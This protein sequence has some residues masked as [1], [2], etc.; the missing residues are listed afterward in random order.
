KSYN[1]VNGKIQ[2]LDN[3][4]LELQSG[5]VTALWGA[6]GS[7]KTTIL[8]ILGSFDTPDEGEV[9]L[10]DCSIPSL[11]GKKLAEFRRN[12]IAVIWQE[13]NLITEL[14]ALE[15]IMIGLQKHAD[16]KT[17]ELLET[18]A[19]RLGVSDLLNKFPGQLSGG[20]RQ[21]ISILRAVIK[22]PKM[23]L[24]DE[25]T[26]NLDWKNALEVFNI[27]LELVKELKCILL[28]AT[29]DER[30]AKMCDR[31]INLQAMA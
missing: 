24:A 13:N 4:S 20:E 30:I 16:S 2:I 10:G 15:N 29:H 22:R 7:G 27:F 25:P 17:Y 5:S 23:I 12:D 31:T 1:V 8:N 19:Q 26:A 21:R 9:T 6:S 14:T 28:V 3:F 18:Y 11:R